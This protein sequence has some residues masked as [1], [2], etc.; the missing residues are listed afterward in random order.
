MR[1]TK[2]DTKKQRSKKLQE[3]MNKVKV[4][5]IVD[6]FTITELVY[7]NKADL[8]KRLGIIKR[9]VEVL[10]YDY[11]YLR[12]EVSNLRTQL[13]NTAQSKFSFKVKVWYKNLL[14]KYWRDEE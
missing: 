1:R 6:N 9:D 7:A 14:F 8:Q 3:A 5:S 11:L 2:S 12:H 10:K 13:T 4:I